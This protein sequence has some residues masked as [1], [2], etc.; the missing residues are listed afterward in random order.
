MPDRHPVFCSPTHL[1]M[2]LPCPPTSQPHC[3]PQLSTLTKPGL[4][5]KAVPAGRRHFPSDGR[6]YTEPRAAVGPGAEP[7]LEPATASA[8]PGPSAGAPGP[9]TAPRVGTPGRGWRRAVSCLNLLEP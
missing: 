9:A 8:L 1:Q 6:R 4:L 2:L 7:D 3:P 5:G